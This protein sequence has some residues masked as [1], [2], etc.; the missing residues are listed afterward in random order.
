MVRLHHTC[1][2]M[3]DAADS[4][5]TAMKR[6]SADLS[7]VFVCLEPVDFRKGINGL[8]ALLE[9]GLEQNPFAA[10]LYVF[11]NRRRDRVKILYWER[12]GFCLW[13]KRLE[14]ERFHWLL[15]VAPDGVFSDTFLTLSAHRFLCK[16]RDGR[17]PLKVVKCGLGKLCIYKNMIIKDKNII[18]IWRKKCTY[19]VI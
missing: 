7:A 18:H 4:G 1:F 2:E 8:A 13:Q 16:G 5:L 14:K 10:A 9:A 12:N 17:S 19:A 3:N 11:S 6:P 15:Q